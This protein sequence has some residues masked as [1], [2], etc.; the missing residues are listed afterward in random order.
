MMAEQQYG[1]ELVNFQGLET[2]AKALVG[3]GMGILAADEKVGTLTKRF[4]KLKIPSTPCAPPRLSG[5]ALHN[6]GF[7]KLHQRRHYV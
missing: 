5:N 1:G 3:D 4:E 6:T 7:G 2:I